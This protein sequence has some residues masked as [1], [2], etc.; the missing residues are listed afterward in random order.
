[1]SKLGKS[2]RRKFVNFRVGIVQPGLSK[3]NMPVDHLTIIG[4]TNSFVQIVT[5]NRLIVYG[6]A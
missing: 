5:D 4:S 3:S 1:M 2:A 6:S